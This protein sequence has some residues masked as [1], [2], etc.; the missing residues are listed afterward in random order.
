M[1]A[2]GLSPHKMPSL[3]RPHLLQPEGLFLQCASARGV[4]THHAAAAWRF[5]NTPSQCLLC[6][7]CP[8][9]PLSSS[10]TPCHRQLPAAGGAETT[11]PPPETTGSSCCLSFASRSSGCAADRALARGG[12][13]RF[14]VSLCPVGWWEG[15]AA[16]RLRWAWRA[17]RRQQALL[18]LGDGGM[19]RREYLPAAGGGGYRTSRDLLLSW[20]PTVCPALSAGPWGPGWHLVHGRGSLA[21]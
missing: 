21:E 8:P 5:V 13:P 19:G 20:A 17:G 3:G 11:P 9:A 1:T 7:L 15:G 18:G 4:G 12:G 16:G 6:L 2:G 10:P 14:P